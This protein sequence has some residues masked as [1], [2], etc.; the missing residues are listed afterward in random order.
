[1]EPTVPK[2][3]FVDPDGTAYVVDAVIGQSLMDAALNNDV[4]GIEG[5]CGGEMACGTCHVYINDE[6][7]TRVEEQVSDELEA[8][9]CLVVGEVRASSR[10]ACQI[11]V[12]A[13]L[14]GLPV[15]VAPS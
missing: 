2:I 9:D 4:P 1:M 13:E 14:A 6:W 12:A 3:H 10:L 11:K 8:I 15:D 7:R 5:A